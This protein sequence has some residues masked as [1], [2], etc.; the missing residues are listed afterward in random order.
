MKK[1]II[2]TISILLLLIGFA[3]MFIYNFSHKA[4]PDYNKNIVIE[5]LENDVEIF[6]DKYAIPHIY[7]KTETDLY[8]A[9]GYVMAQDRL[10]QMDL[11]RR[12]TQGRLAEIFGNEYIDVDLMLRSLQIDEKSNMVLDSTNSEMKATLEAFSKGVNQYIETN[13]KKLPF[14]FRLRNYTPDAWTP[15]NSLNIIG[16]MAWDL[17]TAW[18]SEIIIHQLKEVLNEEQYKS[19]IPS[20][21]NDIATYD[22]H[23]KP[24]TNLLNIEEELIGYNSKIE[25]LG[26]TA[27]GGSNNWAVSGKKSTTGKP[28]LANDMHLNLSIPGTWYQMHIVLKGKYDV[29]GLAVPGAP[30]IIAGHNQNIAWGMTNVML[31]DMDFYVETINPDNTKQ[32]KFNGVWKD[33]KVVKEI[34]KTHEGE[35]YEKEILFTHRGPIISD[36]KEVKNQAISMRWLGNEFSNEYKAVYQLNK[37]NNWNDFLNAIKNFACVSQNFIYSDKEGNIGLHVGAKVPIRK[38][39]HFSIYP[40][41]T[42]EYDWKGFIPFD[43]LPQEYN[44]ECGFVASANSKSAPEDYPYYLSH[45][46]YQPYRLTRIKEMLNAKEKLSVED[47]KNMHGDFQSKLVEKFLPKIIFEVS[48]I[49]DQNQTVKTAT[50]I[51]SKW[52]GNIVAQSGAAAIFEEFYIIFIKNMIKDEM[53]DKLYEKYINYRILTNSIFEYTWLNPFSSWTD[54]ITTPDTKEDFAEIVKISYL[55]TIDSLKIKLGNNPETWEWGKMHK[56]ELEHPF[57]KVKILNL[58]FK[59]KTKAYEIGGS[60]HTVAPYAYSFNDLYKINFGAS[61]RHIFTL[62]NWAT[63]Q[64]IIP[65]GN[66]GQPASK[67]YCDQTEL[68]V[69]NQYHNDLYTR[70]E[71]ENG[72]KYKMIITGN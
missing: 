64:T 22:Y 28:I 50:K 67:H 69:K 23:I 17:G 5:G 20:F 11:I 60:H 33:M 51:L 30:G 4:L 57:A 65:T 61:H 63:S 39:D 44:P 54:N 38:G 45:Y 9:V 55:E 37:A 3:V 10:W 42:D 31:D 43:S 6:R 25:K 19:L 48:K 16:F 2:I 40:G 26:V 8:C 52:D 13:K 35:E 24:D 59:L 72:A 49:Q 46:F 32:Y 47:M 15:A 7:A 27:F 71:V 70:E 41:E 56:F 53:G 62:D 68:Y 36:F 12:A 34:I 1:A 58:A 18:K 66:S 29:T 14:E 21:T